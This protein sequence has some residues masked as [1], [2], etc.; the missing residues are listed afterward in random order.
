MTH[1][2]TIE[3]RLIR[4]LLFDLFLGF[5]LSKIE[6]PEFIYTATGAAAIYLLITAI[7][8]YCLGRSISVWIQP[9]IVDQTNHI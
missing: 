8:G 2:L 4:F 1:K 5:E 3:N 7:F 9:R 6:M